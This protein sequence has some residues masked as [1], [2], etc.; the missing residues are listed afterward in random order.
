[1]GN[2]WDC[3]KYLISHEIKFTFY[4]EPKKKGLRNVVASEP[5]L[6]AEKK[7]VQ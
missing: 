1:M 7:I 5:T 6:R 4:I 2:F 3:R